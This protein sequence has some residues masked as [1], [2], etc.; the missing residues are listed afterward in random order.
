MIKE[1]IGLSN[2]FEFY[3]LPIGSGGIEIKNIKENTVSIM[4]LDDFEVMVYC[5]Q[6]RRKYGPKRKDKV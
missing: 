3:Y 2:N 4:T 5:Y 1:L 6:S